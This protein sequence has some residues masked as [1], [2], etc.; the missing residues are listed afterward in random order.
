LIYKTIGKHINNALREE[1]AEFSI[2][3]KLATAQLEENE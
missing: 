2:V 3:V 1:L